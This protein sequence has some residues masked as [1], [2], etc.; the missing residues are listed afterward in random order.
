MT[1][2]TP[3]RTTTKWTPEKLEELREFASEGSWRLSQ[4]FSVSV[5][6]IKG[7][8][9]RHQIS[10]APIPKSEEGRFQARWDALMKARLRASILRDAA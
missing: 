5:F 2:W 1:K 6:S 8:A 4:R 9:R 10:L 7:V 3:L